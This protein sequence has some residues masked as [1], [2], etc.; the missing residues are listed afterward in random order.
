MKAA[1]ERFAPDPKLNSDPQ[2]WPTER[3][4]SEL[5][6]PICGPGCLFVLATQ[7]KEGADVFILEGDR[8]GERVRTPMQAPPHIEDCII[9]SNHFLLYGATMS[10]DRSYHN[11][12]TPVAFSTQHRYESMR[13]R[14]EAQY[15]S[16]EPIT[17]FDADDVRS[18]LQC[19]CVATTEH[20][21]IV[22]MES[23]GSIT[24]RVYLASS[25]FGK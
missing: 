8:Y 20:A 24:M 23:N 21:I 18:L 13:H 9:A 6:G 14:L 25:K 1:L 7:P 19:A 10:S 3:V 11:F 12:S 22:E 2:I 4:T 15:S 5:K 17:H 16:T